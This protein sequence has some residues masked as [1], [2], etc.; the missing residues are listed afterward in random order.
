[1]KGHSGIE[2]FLYREPISTSIASIPLRFAII[3]RTLPAFSKVFAV[4]NLAETRYFF[5]FTETGHHGI[6][7]PPYSA[8]AVIEEYGTSSHEDRF[9]SANKGARSCFKADRA[10]CNRT[11]TAFSLIPKIVA[12]SFVL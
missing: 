8:F 4:R 11:F 7:L 5:V 3:N 12:V 9:M 10:R 2:P 1:M 6:K